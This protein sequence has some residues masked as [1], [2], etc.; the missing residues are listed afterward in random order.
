MPR[1]CSICHHHQRERIAA[2]LH[3]GTPLRQI[4]GA[5]GVALTSLARH[6]QHVDPGNG[7]EPVHAEQ[8]ALTRPAV[9][10]E[11]IEDLRRQAASVRVQAEQLR[12]AHR[13]YHEYPSDTLVVQMAL[14]LA[15][16]VEL[17][18][19]DDSKWPVGLP[20]RPRI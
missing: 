1:A 2:D 6:K 20:A 4:A 12:S 9:L 18:W 19:P 17:L 3:H 13:P 8:L 11:A 10:R 14:L 16:M 7:T 15:N 5:Y